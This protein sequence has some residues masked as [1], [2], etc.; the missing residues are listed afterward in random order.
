MSLLTFHALLVLLRSS[1]RDG[2]RSLRELDDRTLADIGIDRSE[3]DSIMAESDGRV[4]SARRRIVIGLR[5]A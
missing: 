1:M 5:T 3:I 4:E 2:G